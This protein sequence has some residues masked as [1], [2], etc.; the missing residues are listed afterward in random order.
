[1]VMLSNPS[2]RL[3]VKK[4]ERLNGLIFTLKER[5]RLIAKELAD[6]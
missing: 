1:M 4:A 3:V 6:I 5:G 2:R